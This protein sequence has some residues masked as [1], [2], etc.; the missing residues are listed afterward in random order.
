MSRIY[1]VE[2][3]LDDNV[4]RPARLVRA[5]SRSQAERHVVKGCFVTRVATQDD[6]CKAYE[7]QNKVEMAGTE[8]STEEDEQP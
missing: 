6:I 3:N 4:E 2:L 7:T 8:S 5:N 1:H